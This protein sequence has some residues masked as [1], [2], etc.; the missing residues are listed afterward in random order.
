M[1]YFKY[2]Q[3]GSTSGGGGVTNYY[4]SFYDTTTQTSLGSEA[5]VMTFNNTALSS[6]VSVVT[7]GGKAS[8][9]T[10]ANSGVYNF[11]F[12]AQLL[13]TIG[14]QAQQIYIWFRK[15]GVD[16]PQSNTTL[17]LANNGDL[18]VAAWNFMDS[19][20]A[21]QYIELVWYATDSHIEL[22]NNPAPLG[23]PGI[24]SVIL[25]VDRVG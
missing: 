2:F 15:N 16:I 21:G 12:S 24:P 17:T 8:R 25:T 19:M 7:S 20:N 13:K 1:R 18:I 22:H 3:F 10:V 5:K 14:G 4:G 23:L 9:I 11:Q 6:G